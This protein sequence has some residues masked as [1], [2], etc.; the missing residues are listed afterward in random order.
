MARRARPLAAAG[1][2][3][4]PAYAAHMRALHARRQGTVRDA[5]DEGVP[6]YVG[7]D[8]GGNI[9]HGL[10]AD[11][12]AELVRAGLPAIAALDAGCWGARSWLRRPG[13]DEGA[14]ADLVV[15]PEDPRADVAVLKHPRAVILRG[16]LV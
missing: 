16:R 3:K 2:A 15:Y 13:L 1:E 9:P 5:F 10:V 4:F 12:I 8:A 14:D 11:E 6:V 7:T